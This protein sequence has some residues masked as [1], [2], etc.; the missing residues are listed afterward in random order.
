VSAARANKSVEERITDIE[1]ELAGLDQ[2]F[3]E[4][5]ESINN[6]GDSLEGILELSDIINQI[7]SRVSAL[8]NGQITLILTS[9]ILRIHWLSLNQISQ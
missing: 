1:D 2:K 8:E 9:M 3:V 6:V 7:N 5:N 4:V